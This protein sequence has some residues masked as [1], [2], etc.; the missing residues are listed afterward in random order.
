MYGCMTFKDFHYLSF[1]FHCIQ[2]SSKQLFNQ[3]KDV[4]ITYIRI[5]IFHNKLEYVVFYE[6]I[7]FE[8]FD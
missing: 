8:D 7:K 1:E 6:L 2:F 5:I 3:A 4:L